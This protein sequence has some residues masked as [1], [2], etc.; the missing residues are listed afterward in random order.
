[1]RTLLE[2]MKA[3]KE[4]TFV[5]CLG[6]NLWYRL[7]CHDGLSGWDL[8]FRIPLDEVAGGV[9][10]ARDIECKYYQ[11]WIRKELELQKAEN[12]MIEKARAEWEG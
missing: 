3:A 6:G 1:M 12:E 7:V 2:T 4:I 5:E 9:F 8:K 11:R 10:P